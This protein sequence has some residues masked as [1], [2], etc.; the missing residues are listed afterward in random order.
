M[1]KIILSA[2]LLVLFL[3]GTEKTFAQAVEILPP[4]FREARQPQVALNSKGEIFIAFGKENS[5]YCVRSSDG[6]KTFSAPRQVAT[7]KKLALGMRRGPRIVAFRDQ[8]TVTAISHDDGNF[9]AWTSRDRGNSWS[10]SAKINDAANSARE[11]LAALAGNSKGTLFATWLDLRN[12]KTQLWG[13]NSTDN[14]KTWSK[15]ALVYKSP[16]GSICECCHPSAIFSPDGELHVM[17][18]N[19]LHGSRDMFLAT[20]RDNGKSFSPA[21]KL[22]KET[23]PLNGCPMDGGGLAIDVTGKLIAVWRR[24]NSIF[25][26]E[27]NQAEILLAES[28]MQ[29]V[30]ASRNGKL[31]FIWQEGSKL[32]LKSG[33]APAT[34]LAE[35]GS[36]AATVSGERFS[37]AVWESTA[38]GQSKI[39]AQVLK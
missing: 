23:W 5:I 12:K 28:G 8:I 9:Y 15:N 22:G 37:V 18:R 34:I 13:A 38:N 20:S 27:N 36:Y 6:G 26:I 14:G 31:Y 7:L 19:S 11:G 24:K 4:E 1:N 35:N 10:D 17:W 32:K 39:F 25:E 21:T 2:L 29:P 16:D 3:G 33:S 30:A